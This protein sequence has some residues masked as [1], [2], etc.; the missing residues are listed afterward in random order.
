MSFDKISEYTSLCVGMVT[1]YAVANLEMIHMLEVFVYGFVAA[2]GSYLGTQLFK[3][4]W[5]KVS[6]NKKQQE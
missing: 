6:R 2:G 4:A 5:N 3:A 1:S